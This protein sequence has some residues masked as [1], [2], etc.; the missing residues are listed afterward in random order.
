MMM[1]A[2]TNTLLLAVVSLLAL[3]SAA[4]VHL[5][6]RDVFVPP[7][8]SPT[9]ETVWVVGQQYNVTWNTSNAPVDITN[10][11]GRVVLATNYLQDYENPLASNFSILDGWVTV[12]APN[13]TTGNDYTIVLFG[14]SG[15]YSPNFTITDAAQDHES[16]ILDL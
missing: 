8:T 13:V 7:I 15:N 10:K 1:S 4:P 2:F 9:N 14:D 12:T 3:V 11:M 5:R 16:F 6:L